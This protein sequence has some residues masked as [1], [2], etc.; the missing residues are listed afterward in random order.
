VVTSIELQPFA[1]VR[2]RYWSDDDF[3]TFQFYLAEH[4]DAGD[5][6]PGSG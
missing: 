2:D 4:P 5:V 3:A 1:A 6:I